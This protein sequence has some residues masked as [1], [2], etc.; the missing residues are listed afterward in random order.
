MRHDFSNCAGEARLRAIPG[1]EKIMEQKEKM[2][3]EEELFDLCRRKQA[4]TR[5]AGEP[6]DMC[7][8][9]AV[10]S[11]CEHGCYMA[12]FYN[13]PDTGRRIINFDFVR[14]E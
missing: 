5:I 9:S 14:E 12:D 1:L 3:R 2:L 10:M 13:D 6:A 4:Q 7:Q 8:V 11:V